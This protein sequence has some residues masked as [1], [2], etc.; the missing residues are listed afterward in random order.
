MSKNNNRPTLEELC[1]NNIT[2]IN[3]THH[4][5]PTY[6]S[7]YSPIRDEPLTI[8][9]V[10][11]GMSGVVQMM[12]DYFTNAI[13]HVCD[14]REGH[15]FKPPLYHIGLYPNVILH[16]SAQ[17]FDPDY[18]ENEFVNNGLLFDIIVEDTSPR[19]LD[20]MSTTLQLY[21]PLLSPN[22]ML[23]IEDLQEK[24]WGNILTQSVP[25]GRLRENITV[26]DL[27]SSGRYDDILFVVKN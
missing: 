2:D 18:I 12:K 26:Y 22:G 21:C 17:P 3:T 15:H 7:L 14:G 9:I 1:P 13:I 24:E 23:I 5:I 16:S 11:A 6:E 25:E 27:T 8:L 4:Y 19:T 20:I 10:G